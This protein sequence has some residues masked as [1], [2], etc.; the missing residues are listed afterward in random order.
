MLLFIVVSECEQ[1]I[2]CDSVS[3][4]SN[5]FKDLAE[6][7]AETVCAMSAAKSL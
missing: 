6:D 4:A 2:G 1:L 7:I 3:I 5:Y